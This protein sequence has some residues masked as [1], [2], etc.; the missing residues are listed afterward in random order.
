MH[1]DTK[2]KVP[3]SLWQLTFPQEEGI[4]IFM[5][6]ISKDWMVLYVSY[7]YLILCCLKSFFPPSPCQCSVLML[8]IPPPPPTLP[9]HFDN[10][11]FS[12][13]VQHAIV[14]GGW[15]IMGSAYSWL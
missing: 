13:G 6:D 5:M 11:V 1:A 14:Q 7:F 12:V 8:I 15:S 10:A 3:Y 4:L 9:N 2:I